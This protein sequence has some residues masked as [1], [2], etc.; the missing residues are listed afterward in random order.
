MDKVHVSYIIPHNGREELLAF[1][2]KSLLCQTV[3][4]FEII[5]IDNSSQKANIKKAVDE[6]RQ[7]GLNIKLFFVDPR[8][9]PFSHD[10][11]KFEGKFNPAIQQNVGVKKANGKIIV[12]TSP[13][14]VNASTN[15]ENII[16]KF[17]NNKSKL[18]LGWIDE[19]KKE[20]FGI[21]MKN[22]YNLDKMKWVCRNNVRNLISGG[23]W[24]KEGQWRP[25]LYFLGSMLKNDFVRIGG[26]EELF[27]AGVAWEDD[28]FSRRCIM[29]SIGCSLEGSIGG[30][31]LQH[32]RTYQGNSALRHST[33]GRLFARTKNI[34]ANIGHDWGSDNYIIGEF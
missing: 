14:V 23:A 7:A 16:K 11:N 34:I 33:N 28:E 24:C 32:T 22:N 29:N 18:L 3:K 1:N 26:I 25:T 21:I 27:M 9:C 8:L 12:L 31:H 4:N 17:E 30:I 19:M 13:E 10:G 20:H 6:F 15:V 5:V 2:L